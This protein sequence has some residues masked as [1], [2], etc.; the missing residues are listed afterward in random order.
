MGEILQKGYECER[1]HHKWTPR[2]DEKPRV[3]PKCKSPYWD[4]AKKK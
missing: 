2:F 1:C 4:V 3:C